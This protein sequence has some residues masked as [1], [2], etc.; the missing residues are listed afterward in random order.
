MLSRFRPALTTTIRI[1]GSLLSSQRLVAQRQVKYQTHK[2]TSWAALGRVSCVSRMA[3]S[4]SA[5]RPKTCCKTKSSTSISTVTGS[6]PSTM[7]RRRFRVTSLTRS[8][9]LAG[10]C[11]RRDSRLSNTSLQISSLSK[12]F[13][14]TAKL[15]RPLKAG[16]AS[17]RVASQKHREKALRNV[18]GQVSTTSR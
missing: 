12:R 4:L 2:S 15:K 18:R 13:S 17:A 6:E 14:K 7:M 11:S 9:T 16:L 1:Q 3:A 8:T 5:L 10:F